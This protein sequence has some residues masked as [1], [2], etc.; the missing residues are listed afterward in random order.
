MTM[1]EILNLAV[2]LK[3][4]SDDR[5][6]G[7][8]LDGSP[9]FSSLRRAFTNAR[10]AEKQPGFTMAS[11]P[12][13]W[14]DILEEVPPLL[15]R[16]TKDL[17]LAAWLSE[18]MLR[19]HSLAGLAQGLRLLHGLTE[20]FWDDVH[21]R[22]EVDAD[23][24][25]AESR[26]AA[27]QDKVAPLQGVFGVGDKSPLAQTLILVPLTQH[28]E[29]GP[30]SLW[31]YDIAVA[32]EAVEADAKRKQEI[33][34]GKIVV[35]AVIAAAF[36]RNDPAFSRALVSGA[37]DAQ[38]WLQRLEHV[39]AQKCGAEA[40]SLAQPREA[41]DRL[42]RLLRHLA[43]DLVASVEADA[44]AAPAVE[45]A[46]TGD[47]PAAI[48]APPSALAIDGRDQAFAMLGD[49]A[50]FLRRFDP[51]SLVPDM[52][53]SVIARGRLPVHDLLRDLIPDD[54]ARREL[55]LRGGMAVPA[56]MTA[57]MP[58][59]DN[60]PDGGNAIP[61]PTATAP[62]LTPRGRAESFAALREIAAFFQ[63]TE[64]QSVVAAM[65]DNVIRRGSLPLHE[66]LRDLIPDETVR[67][68]FYH[69]GGMQPPTP[70]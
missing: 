44:A 50:G 53:E 26:V 69:R 57:A 4:I 22:G 38:I 32:N 13:E 61:M 28:G 51:Q 58:A 6:C 11:P 19:Q 31:D 45:Q 1:A 66:L 29:G 34:A 16:Q 65:I 18:A 8:D 20:R 23:L 70:V 25:E 47:Q 7:E 55:Y 63:R 67:S 33:A 14:R 49:I 30:F 5:P 60:G 3:P 42:Y 68:E 24:S 12:P 64:P 10:K 9:D 41:L 37:H 2:L 56:P 52:L 39:L 27:I 15:E 21:P 40:P 54:K 36:R 46:A 17:R 59:A 62:L 35:T 43:P 48:A